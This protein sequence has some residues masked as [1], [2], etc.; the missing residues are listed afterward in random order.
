MYEKIHIIITLIATAI[1]ALF[2]YIFFESLLRTAISLIITIVVFFILGSI[3]KSSVDKII[4]ENKNNRAEEEFPDN[5]E[6]QEEEAIE[7]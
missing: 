2:S 5:E 1:V 4:E 3:F 6:F 7:E